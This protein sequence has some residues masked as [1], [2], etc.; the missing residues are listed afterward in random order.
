MKIQRPSAIIT[1]KTSKARP[2]RGLFTRNRNEIQ[3]PKQKL[4]LKSPQPPNRSRESRSRPS[5]SRARQ[6]ALRPGQRD[7]ALI[8]DALDLAKFSRARSEKLIE[9]PAI[10][11]H[12]SETIGAPPRWRPVAVSS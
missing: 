10:P 4:P 3:C 5:N 8:C 12:H 2:K 6:P 7:D 11:D 9:R 1:D